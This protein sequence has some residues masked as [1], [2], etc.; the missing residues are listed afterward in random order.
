[1]RKIL[2]IIVSALLFISCKTVLLKVKGIK[3]PK[4]ETY[5]TTKSYLFKKDMDSS[6]VLYYK[7]VNSF[8]AAIKKNYFQVP[9]AFFFDKN[10]NFVDYRKTTTDC[11]AKIDG[12]IQ[13]LNTF[14]EAKKDSTK[15][16][17]ELKRFLVGSNKNLLNE[18]NADITVFIT[19]AKFVGSLNKE[20]AF[21]WVQL[22]EEAKQKG[23]N[24]NYYL[25]NCDF[26]ESWNLTE[27][28][29]K[30]LGFN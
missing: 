15:T 20:K 24:V 8:E 7:D 25:L 6:R 18:K 16:M 13:D 2:F 28:E 21:D 9:N 17:A 30:G 23:I 1:M 19:W 11:N 26:Q 4:L 10:G 29:K 14:N 22:L 5:A 12:F 3:D 27:E